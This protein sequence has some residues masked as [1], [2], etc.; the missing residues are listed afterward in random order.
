MG[1]IFEEHFSHLPDPRVERTKKHKLIDII[2]IAMCGVI[3]PGSVAAGVFGIAEWD[4]VARYI[5][6]GVCE[7]GCGCISTKFH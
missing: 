6:A 3:N 5:W 4:T 2:A 1:N 7:A